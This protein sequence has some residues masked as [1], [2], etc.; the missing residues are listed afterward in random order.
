MTMFDEDSA[1]DFLSSSGIFFE[2]LFPDDDPKLAQ[3]INLS[4]VFA[5]GCADAEYVH[6]HELP[7]LAELFF[8]Y[9]FAGV[10]YWVAREKRDGIVPE[11]E[12]IKRRIQFVANEEAIRQEEPVN[13]KRA[14][15][16]RQYTIGE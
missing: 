3:T 15:L 10:C 14:Y 6:D 2:R 1:R 13:Y 5:W 8:E 7:R 9:G 11:F 16:K 4:D 12:D